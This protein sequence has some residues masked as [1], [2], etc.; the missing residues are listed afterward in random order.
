MASVAVAQTAGFGLIVG[1]LMRWRLQA[2]I[3]LMQA[4]QITLLVALSFLAGLGCL[5]AIVVALF[6]PPG[7][8]WARPLAIYAVLALSVLVALAIAA[9]ASAVSGWIARFLPMRALIALFLLASLDSLAAAAALIVLIP[10]DAGLGVSVLLPAILVALAAGYLSGM[11]CGLGPLDVTLL[12]LVPLSDASP[13]LAALVAFRMIYFGATAL[14]GGLWA[15]IGV[16]PDNGARIP[17][18]APELTSVKAAAFLGHP[19]ESWLS[20]APMAEAGLLRQGHLGLVR[21][22]RGDAALIAKELTQCTVALG[23]PIGAPGQHDDLIDA[24][25]QAANRR[26]RYPVLYKCSRQLADG[27][28]RRGYATWPVAKEA[29]LNPQDFTLNLPSRATLRRKLRRAEKAGVRIAAAG[30]RLPLPD[31]AGVARAW[32]QHKGP[33]RG[34]STGRFTPDYLASQRVWLAYHDG[35]LVAWISFHTN[36]RELALDLMRHTPAAPDGAM[37]ALI[38]AAIRDATTEGRTRLSLAAVADNTGWI[39]SRINRICGAEGLARFKSSFDPQYDPLFIAARSH[40]ALFQAVLDI[41]RAVQCAAPAR[42]SL[43]KFI[44]IMTNMKLLH[45]QA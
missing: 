45:K 17:H 18:D 13:L 34:F 28:A 7:F 29:W 25:T 39:R 31:M 8:E 12:A 43:V 22:A 3:S 4:T 20:D 44:I 32:T 2:G 14:V 27:A 24:L 36:R 9:P 19:L 21:S 42:L 23:G 35:E 16:R 30:D 10:G 6:P 26:A 38:H 40:F 41:R 37:H 15:L 11:P 1:A 33:E 5:A